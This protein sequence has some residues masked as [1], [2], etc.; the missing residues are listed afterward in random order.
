MIKQVAEFRTSQIQTSS[1]LFG[2]LVARVDQFLTGGITKEQLSED[3]SLVQLVTTL[4]AKC[5][6]EEL[7]SIASGAKELPGEDVP[8]GR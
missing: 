6:T 3:Y 4:D 1:Y 7:L 2:Y 8:S 5:S